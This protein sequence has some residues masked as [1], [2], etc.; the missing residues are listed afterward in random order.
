LNPGAYLHP[1]VAVAAVPGTFRRVDSVSTA[2]EPFFVFR[3]KCESPSL[4]QRLHFRRQLCQPVRGR[5][6]IA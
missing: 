3:Q 5:L 6:L 4:E 2:H 1:V